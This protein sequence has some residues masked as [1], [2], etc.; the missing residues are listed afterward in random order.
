MT[1]TRQDLVLGTIFFAA[2]IGVG[3]V[4]IVLSDFSFTTETHRF[5]LYSDDVG[6]LRPGDP[7]LL[8][9]MAAGKVETIER[10]PEPE[11][12][13]HPS[14]H[15]AFVG[16]DVRCTVEIGI[17]LEVDPLLH[18]RDD[19]RITIED[20]G[21]LGGKLVRIEAGLGEQLV[22]TETV[23]VAEATDAALR[24]VGTLI[25]ENREPLNRILEN[26][27]EVAE[28]VNSGAGPLGRLVRDDE[29]GD[30]VDAII[31]NLQTVTNGLAAGEGTIGQL[32]VDDQLYEDAQVFMSD[33]RAAMERVKRGEGSVGKLIQEDELYDQATA[34][35]D[36][37]QQ[38]A[39]G[40]A[41]GEGTA[42]KL[43]A[44]SKLY[45]D[46]EAT[47]ASIR[48]AVDEARAGK[49]TI[50][51]LLVDETLYTEATSFF[52]TAARVGTRVEEI[53]ISVQ[54][55][56]GLLAALLTDKELADDLRNIMD[57]VLGA[58]EDARETAP[59]QSLGSLLFGTF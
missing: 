55:G 48:E 9:G 59:V 11:V 52:E 30:R 46:L 28:Q 15:P 20:R 8:Y 50:G 40:L 27:A 2:L 51:K 32:L 6:Y 57:Q 41:A 44:D 53:A 17:K 24:A 56:E 4:T 35:M 12:L 47:V 54:E 5:E 22:S 18:L 13:T 38:V 33:L 34:I 19:H 37:L 23:F 21:L 26:F 36:S 16:R 31:D 3:A 25:E 45:D 29:L 39:D 58:I 42:G 10:L 14:T 49:G 1:S 7:V 43:L